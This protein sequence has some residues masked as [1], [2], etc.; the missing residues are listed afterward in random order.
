M[1]REDFALVSDFQIL[2]VWNLPN[3]WLWHIESVPPIPGQ[4]Y[5]DLSGAPLTFREL[6]LEVSAANFQL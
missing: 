6:W 5:W 4:R 2:R 3:C 1:R